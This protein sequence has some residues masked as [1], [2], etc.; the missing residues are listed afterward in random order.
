VSCQRALGLGRVVGD[1]NQRQSP[2]FMFGPYAG[3][4]TEVVLDFGFQRRLVALAGEQVIG[5]MFDD[6]VSDRDLATHGGDAHQRSLELV[7]FGQVVEEFGNGSDF[8]GLLGHA[9]LA[10]S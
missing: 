1:S 4:G 10:L 6:L 3:A 7:G 2:L 8:F 9:E 5:L